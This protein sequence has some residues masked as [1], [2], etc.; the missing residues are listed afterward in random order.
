MRAAGIA[1]VV[2]AMACRDASRARA[3]SPAEVFAR[4]PEQARRRTNPLQRDPRAAAAGAKLFAQHCAV[5]HGRQGEGTQRAPGMSEA[6][7]AAP[8][9]VFWVLTN[10]V[11]RRGMPEWSRLTEARRWQIVT[12]LQRRTAPECP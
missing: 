2:L 4:V 9:E 10:G 1:A 8:G 6:R 7:K 3:Q 11:V 5:C 12:F